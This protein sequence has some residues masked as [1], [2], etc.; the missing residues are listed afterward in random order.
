MS[1]RIRAAT[2]LGAGLWLLGAWAAH[3]AGHVHGATGAPMEAM[4]EQVFR[5]TAGPWNVEAR[6]I[7]MNAEL[8][9]SGVSAAAIAKLSSRHHLM[10]ILTDP[11]TGKTV[12]DVD[13]EVRIAG[14]DNTSSSRVSLVPMGGH[15]GSDV[16]LPKS[17][18]YRFELETGGGGR[19]GAATFEYRLKP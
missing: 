16:R 10:V 18:T 6:L 1:L 13:G 11:K 4:G 5:G 9:R 7:D 19:N 14:P 17:G 8:A 2:F 3:A 15:I 12:V